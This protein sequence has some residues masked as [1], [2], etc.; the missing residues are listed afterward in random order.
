MFH[1]NFCVVDINKQSFILEPA[2]APWSVQ[3]A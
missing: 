1:E 3:A 2:A